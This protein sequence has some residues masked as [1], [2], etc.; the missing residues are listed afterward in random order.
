LNRANREVVAWRRFSKGHD[1]DRKPCGRHLTKRSEK[2]GMGRSGRRGRF[3]AR[4]GWR[5]CEAQCARRLGIDKDAR[6]ERVGSTMPPEIRRETLRLLTPSMRRWKSPS[7]RPSERKATTRD[8]ARDR[9]AARLGGESVMTKEVLRSTGI[10]PDGLP[11]GDSFCN[12]RRNS[13]NRRYCLT[14][15]LRT[16]R[17]NCPQ[18]TSTLTCSKP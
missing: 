13:I 4:G 11:G 7:C 16:V 2:H 10:E 14:R 15:S 3:W 17:T 18:S 8:I 5:S 6:P 12:L 9:R 1:E